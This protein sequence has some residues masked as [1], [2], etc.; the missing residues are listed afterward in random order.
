MSSDPILASS[1]TSSGLQDE[2]DSHSLPTADQLSQALQV[3]VFDADGTKTPLS[4][5][6]KGKRTALIFVRHFCTCFKPV[7]R[8]RPVQIRRNTA[9]V[10]GCVNC[11]EYLRC[12]SR[13]IPPT[14]LPPN[15]QSKQMLRLQEHLLTNHQ[16]LSLV[17]DHTSPS[18][19]MLRIPPRSIPSTQIPPVS[20][21]QFST[22]NTTWPRAQV[23]TSNG[24]ICAMLEAQRPDSGGVSGAP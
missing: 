2:V 8:C 18:L 5:L 17:A 16:Y 10:P 24:T 12:V 9:D 11:Q 6:V 3:E 15:T 4:E 19:P 21:I 23:V 7:L 13:S 14:N 22:S 20:F 1:S